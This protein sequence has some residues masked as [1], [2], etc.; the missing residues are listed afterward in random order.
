MLDL[1]QIEVG[2]MAPQSQPVEVGE[3]LRAS[4]RALRP[5]AEAK[6]IV[7]EVDVPAELPVVSLD[8]RLLGRIVTS[9]VGN[10]VK[11]TDLGEVRVRARHDGE[12]LWI[13]VADTG[14]GIA[15]EAVA[16]LFEP[17]EQASDGH[18]RTHEG[19]GLGL[20]IA[21]DVAALMGGEVTVES[22]LGEGSRFHVSVPAPLSNLATVALATAGETVVCDVTGSGVAGKRRP[23]RSS[24]N[25]R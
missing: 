24:V 25:D 9:L 12:R 19:N 8:P 3:Y 5:L 22:A 7:L 2:R 1:A 21:R 17:F 6:G 23:A 13:E 14:I 18:G 15:P 16:R 10:A 4:V 11:F 20:S